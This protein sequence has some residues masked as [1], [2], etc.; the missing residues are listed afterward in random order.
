M[1]LMIC[2]GTRYAT[3]RASMG[4]MCP[5][6]AAESVAAA[7]PVITEECTLTTVNMERHGAH[8]L[9]VAVDQAGNV[10]EYRCEGF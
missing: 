5:V 8:G 6:K 7:M 1:I 2:C 3:V 4:H 10:I 9:R